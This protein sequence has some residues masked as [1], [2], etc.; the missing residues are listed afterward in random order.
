MYIYEGRHFEDDP[1]S[2]EAG[3]KNQ[4]KHDD[5]KK[6]NAGEIAQELRKTFCVVRAFESIYWLK[7]EHWILSGL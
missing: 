5:K 2:L 6:K 1:D 7:R 4:N 3:I